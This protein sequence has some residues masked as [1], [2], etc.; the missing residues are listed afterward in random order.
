MVQAPFLRPYA[1]DSLPSGTTSDIPLRRA[2]YYVN[3]GMVSEAVRELEALEPRAKSVVSS[4]VRDATQR[5]CTEQ[6]LRLARSQ[7]T[8]ELASYC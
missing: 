7:A 5:L 3:K 8:V 1:D 6:A 2:H 4:W